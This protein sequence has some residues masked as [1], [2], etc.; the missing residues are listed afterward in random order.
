M[1]EIKVDAK[2]VMDWHRESFAA[3][4]ASPRIRYS[5]EV[6]LLGKVRKVREDDHRSS[7]ERENVTAAQSHGYQDESYGA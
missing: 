5:I 2:T 4:E 1:K 6:P 7:I 3:W